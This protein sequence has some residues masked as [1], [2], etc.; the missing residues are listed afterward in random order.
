MKKIFSKTTL[1]SK[2]SVPQNE[3]ANFSLILCCAGSSSRFASGEKKE[4]LAFSDFSYDDSLGFFGFVSVLSENIA[5][6]IKLTNLTSIVLL[7]P[8]TDGQKVQEILKQDSRIREACTILD[9]VEKHSSPSRAETLK[10]LNVYLVAGGQSRQETVFKGL[11]FLYELGT[12][13]NSPVLIH[14]AARPFFSL[15]LA[16]NILENLQS[17]RAVIPG[18][19]VVDTQK[20]AND[21][22]YVVANLKRDTL[23]AVQTPQGFF[24][25]EIYAAHS[26]LH[27]DMNYSDDSEIFF[28]HFPKSKILIIDGE[29][30]NKKITYAC[31]KR[32]PCE[33]ASVPNF[34]I[35]FGYDL[36]RLVEGKGLIL[37]GVKLE[38]KKACLAHSDGDA[39]LHALCDALLGATAFSDIGELFPP[40]DKRY[41]DASSVELLKKAWTMT[42]EK[43]KWQIQNIDCVL[44]MEEPKLL[45]YREKI[46]QSIAKILNIEKSRIFLKAKTAEKTGAIGKGEAIEVFVTALVLK[47]A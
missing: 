30:E 16:K 24:L 27:N 3:G 12:D 29:P 33:Q 2:N 46:R 21:K 45:P 38:S 9:C 37:G 26:A 1:T 43:A 23:R 4:Y 41:K 15:K 18:I 10:K 17:H 22:N 36:H 20:K 28:T 7:I 19:P 31:D 25:K 11:R 6:F 35:G 13:P 8:E 34:R 42:N 40:S 39:L 5:K 44:V 47:L 32:Q 14:D